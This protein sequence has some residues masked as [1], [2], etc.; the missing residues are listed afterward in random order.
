[1][2]TRGGPRHFINNMK[3]TLIILRAISNRG[4]TGTLDRLIKKLKELPGFLSIQ[5]DKKWGNESFLVGKLGKK[6]IGVITFGDPGCGEEFEACLDDCFNNDCNV[7]VAA[8]RSRGEIFNR[9]YNLGKEEEYN[10]IETSPIYLYDSWESD[11]DHDML[12][13]LEANTLLS[14]I[15]Q[16]ILK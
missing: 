15:Q 14:L 6:T 2:P 3:R 16:D 13:D 12:N 7:I 9:M 10:L 1:M 11:I 5:D 8:T 4:K